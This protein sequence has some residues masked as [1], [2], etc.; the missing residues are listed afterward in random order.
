M[1]ARADGVPLFIE[2][3]TRAV[4]GLGLLNGEGGPAAPQ[5]SLPALAI[6]STLQDSLMARLDQL[7]PAKF[8]AQ[9]ASAIGR[10]FSYPLLTAI[11]PLPPERLRGGLRALE[12]AGL[13]LAKDSTVGE[14][15]VFK[16]VLVQEVAYQTLLRSRRHELHSQIAHALEERFPQQARDA[17]EL[18]AHH[19]TE[20]GDTE[21]AVAGWLAAGERACERSEYSEA[22]GHLRK[23]VELV[24][25]LPDPVQRRDQELALLLA[26]G[27]VLMM[28]VG[29][30]TP[31]VAR[32]YARAL[33]ICQDIPKS[34]LHFAA[35]WGR[36][37]A[38]MD[39]RAGRDRAD[40]LLD[41]ALELGDPA[42]LVQAHHCQWATLYM[43]GAHEECCRHADAGIALYDPE[44]HRSHALLYGG[45]DA[46]VCALGERALSCWLLGRLNDSLASVR[47]A[48][49]WAESL[50][51]V[52]SRVHAMDYALQISR[53]RREAPEVARLASELVAFAD[54]QRLSEHR[55]KGMVFRGWA[56]AHLG[57]VDGSLR[58][59]REA[60]AWEEEAGT[61]EDFPLYYEMFAEVCGRAGR[62]TEGL[63]AVGKAFAQ[64]E[65]G[66][67]VYWNAELHR[68][69]GELLL[70]AG[71]DRAEV[72]ACFEQALADARSQGARLLE[73]RAAAS[74]ARLQRDE[75]RAGDAAWRLRA[76]YA[77][78]SQGLDAPDLRDAQALLEALP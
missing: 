20:A 37:R 33:E 11:A 31:E 52:G 38:A 75:G 26:L 71:G 15:Y 55:A 18:L 63:D 41:L 45:H 30:G 67:L 58:E 61:P 43:L 21:R 13:V 7:G 78:F 9:L 17:P 29:A 36:W 19:W 46:K 40:E 34:G 42:H 48:N 74:L 68:R 54:E 70:E 44:L 49:E 24:V 35:R 8:V 53:L 56:N 23:G 69:R 64:A 57:D 72:A 62:F 77:G 28:T 65:R 32:L 66:R 76:A 25:E 27:P 51:H 10:E 1:C 60:L 4:L 6:P 73:L 22:I 47:S 2:E 5:A 39:H 50:D 12:E 14:V 3:L 16:H 59:M